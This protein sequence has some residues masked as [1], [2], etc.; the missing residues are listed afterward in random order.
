MNTQAK[1]LLVDL[2]IEHKGKIYIL[3]DVVYT[4]SG[5]TYYRK[6]VL[7]KLKITEPVRVIK[8]KPIKVIGQT[9]ETK[10]T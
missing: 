9:N 10:H 8:Y 7:A 4:P 2:T 3:K 6:K 1:I 5:E